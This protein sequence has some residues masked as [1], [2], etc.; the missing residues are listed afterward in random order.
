MS[1]RINGTETTRNLVKSI[2]KDFKKNKP[3]MS[4]VDYSVSLRDKRHISSLSTDE[5]NGVI[6]NVSILYVNIPKHFQ[7]IHAAIGNKTGNILIHQKPF[8]MSSKKALKK[9][10]TFLSEL[11]PENQTKPVKVSSNI[12][13]FGPIEAK[14]SSNYHVMT[15][16]FKN[17]TLKK[18]IGG[19]NSTVTVEVFEPYKTL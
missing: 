1:I 18:N 13:H 4:H 3:S 12:K 15:S 6:R 11:Q 8:F 5:N 2:V 14:S 19:S 9:I 7:G 16:E 10:L 17:S